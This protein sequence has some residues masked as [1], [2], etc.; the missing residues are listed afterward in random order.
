[1]S[2]FL[3]FYLELGHNGLVC[4][5][6]WTDSEKAVHSLKGNRFRLRDEE[7][8]EGNGE[9]HERGE[10]EVNAI[11]H[12]E[13]HLRGEAGDDEVPKPIVGGGR[14]LSKCTHIL[15]KH[16]RIYYPRCAI[17]RRGVESGPQVEEK[18][19]SNT[20]GSQLLFHSIRALDTGD[21]DVGTNEPHAHATADCTAHKKLSAAKFVDEEQ[22]P[23]DSKNSL[24]DAL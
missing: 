6:D 20:A 16:L 15:I 17:P 21:F 19:G 2:K 22:E 13:E 8:D 7:V 1:M 23:D 9:D 12:G 3:I 11:T 24:D 10:E 5:S 18:D 14:C 4:F